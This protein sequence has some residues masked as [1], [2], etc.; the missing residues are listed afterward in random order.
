MIVR[1]STTPSGAAHACSSSNLPTVE[2][3]L[4]LHTDLG[5]APTWDERTQRLWFVD[6]NN[7]KIYSCTEDGKDLVSI[8]TPE[9]VGTIA[10]TTDKNV[11]LAAMNRSNFAP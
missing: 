11:L 3:L 1:E 9:T 6:I 7:K 8:D 2:L 10:L 5:E 4:D